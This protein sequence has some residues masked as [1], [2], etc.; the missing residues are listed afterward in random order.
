MDRRG[1]IVMVVWLGL[2]VVAG[3]AGALVLGDGDGAVVVAVGVLV[4]AVVTAF[5]WIATYRWVKRDRERWRAR[6]GGTRD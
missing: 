2:L 4:V 6:F 5:V 1:W 3:T